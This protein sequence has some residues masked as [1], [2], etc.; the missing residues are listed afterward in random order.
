MTYQ[1][2]RALSGLNHGDVKVSQLAPGED[3]REVPLSGNG[4]AFVAHERLLAL[5]LDDITEFS[6]ADDAVSWAH[7]QLASHTSA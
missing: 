7:A 6:S 1:F 2:A 3:A 5:E 4:R